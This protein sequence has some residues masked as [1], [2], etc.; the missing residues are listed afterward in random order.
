[1]FEESVQTSENLGTMYMM[2]FDMHAA[3]RTT[4]SGECQLLT[5]ECPPPPLWGS[6]VRDI[7][8]QPS[9]GIIVK[10]QIIRN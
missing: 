3:S 10:G 9:Q 8:A 7:R 1:M 4:T 5:E 2:R 6:L